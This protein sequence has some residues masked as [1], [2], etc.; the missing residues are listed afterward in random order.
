MKFKYKYSKLMIAFLY[1]GLV[2]AL[3]CLIINVIRLINAEDRTSYNWASFISTILISIAFFVLA[4][5]MLINSYYKVDEK[6][7]T[8]CWGFLKNQLEIKSISRMVLDSTNNKLFVYYNEDNFFVIN[9]KTID[10]TDLITEVRK[11]NKNV[12]FE[13]T[14]S[15]DESNPKN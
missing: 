11:F 15:L 13:F 12:S 1:A 10:A 3:A 7:L 8:L 9:A 4:L 14:S 5:S 2:L 6:H